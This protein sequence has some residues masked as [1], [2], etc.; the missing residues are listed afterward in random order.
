M[1]GIV[2]IA[3]LEG[4]PPHATRLDE[5]LERAASSLRHRGPDD[6]GT[7]VR[8][9]V[10]FGH[11]RLSLLDLSERGHQPMLDDEKNALTFNGE[12]YNFVELKG[13]F[14]G[15]A[16][17]GHSDTEVLLKGLAR[18]NVEWLKSLDGMFAFGFFSEANQELLL[19]VD[20]AGKKPLYTYWDGRIFAF[21]SEIKAFRHLEGLD[22]TLNQD[23]V[24]TSLIYGYV[25]CPHSIYRFIRKLPAGHFQKVSLQTGPK[26]VESY[27]DL[28]VGQTDWK[29]DERHAKARTRELLSDAVRKRLIADV[30]VGCFLSGGL[31]SSA[32]AFEAARILPKENL[33]TFAAGF[34]NDEESKHYDETPYAQQVAKRIGSLHQIL[35]IDASQIDAASIMRHFDEPFGDS[36][37]IPTYLL[38]QQTARHV[39]AVLSGDGGD[40]LFGGY[41]RFR[42]GLLSEKYQTLWQLALSPL[43]LVASSPHSLISKLNRFRSAVSYPLLKRLSVWNAFFTEDELGH[44]VGD[45]AQQ[46]LERLRQWDDRTH[47]LPIGEKILYFNFKTYLFDDLLP[48]IDRMGMAHGLEVRSPFLDTRLVEFAFRLP[49]ELKFDAYRTKKILKIAYRADLGKDITDRAKHGFAFPL[50]TFFGNRPLS[51]NSASLRKLFP[52]GPLSLTSNS[53]WN[54]SS[55]QFMIFSLEECLTQIE[56]YAH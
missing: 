21:A 24:K 19:A 9:Q 23:H 49:T 29:I 54:R 42:A 6:S 45:H 28:P 40:E 25:P 31:D 41:L 7:W 26:T 12:I 16:F 43:S 11:R 3:Y 30:P 51:S 1:C 34:S 48:K 8:E 50:K 46:S 36:S 39:K 38:C 27:W 56:S 5:Q 52:K 14:P 20:P 35:Q 4:P 18:K 13:Y 17:H 44:F 15:Q 22:F 33:L 32:V 53:T 2:G 47:G 10:G 55:K 37:A